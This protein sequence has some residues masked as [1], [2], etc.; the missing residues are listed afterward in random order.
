VSLSD[1]VAYTL[2]SVAVFQ[3]LRTLLWRKDQRECSGCPKRKSQEKL[4]QK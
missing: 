4:V 1:F 3:L 2:I